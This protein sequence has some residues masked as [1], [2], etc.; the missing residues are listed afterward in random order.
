MLK[1]WYF[2]VHSAH[3]LLFN[4]MIISIIA[5]V[6]MCDFSPMSAFACICVIHNDSEEALHTHTC[7]IYHFSHHTL[8]IYNVLSTYFIVLLKTL[9]FAQD[10]ELRKQTNNVCV[11]IYIYIGLETE[12]IRKRFCQIQSTQSCVLPIWSVCPSAGS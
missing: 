6:R 3:S 8:W 1:C 9:F 7:I 10:I 11:Y 2:A 5:S 4:S 12:L